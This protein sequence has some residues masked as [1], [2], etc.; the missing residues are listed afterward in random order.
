[1]ECKIS[2][3]CR[4]QISFHYKSGTPESAQL[5]NYTKPQVIVICPT[6]RSLIFNI[7]KINCRS[8]SVDSPRVTL[9]MNP[10]INKQYGAELIRTQ[11]N[12]FHVC[13]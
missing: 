5:H 7:R 6:D 11:G 9:R 13:N 2:V 8:P 3:V 12:G 1:M 4:G 10:V